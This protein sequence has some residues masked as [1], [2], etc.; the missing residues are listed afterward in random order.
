ML[1]LTKDDV[2]VQPKL[3]FIAYQVG[4]AFAGAQLVE[5]ADP[6]GWPSNTKF[7]WLNTPG[8]PDGSVVSAARLWQA[9]ER[10]RELS[11]VIL[12]DE[13]YAEMGW[14]APCNDCIPCILDPEVTGGDNTKILSIYSLS[15]QSNL[16]GYWAAFAAGDQSLIAKLV[17]LRMHSGT[18]PAMPVQKTITAGLADHEHVATQKDTHRKRRDLL[19]PTLVEYG[20]EIEDSE[21]DLNL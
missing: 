6:A 18:M 17:N 14:E 7:I 12:N 9:A 15:K 16:A 10:A 8:N 11:G 19:F 13:H 21:A 1:G 5:S 4:T 2:A 3:A 20:F